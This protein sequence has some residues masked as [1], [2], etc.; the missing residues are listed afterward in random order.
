MFTRA[1]EALDSSEIVLSVGQRWIAISANLL[2]SWLGVNFQQVAIR[3]HLL[4][5]I[6]TITVP[7]SSDDACR[8]G[9]N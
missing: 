3:Q 1:L 2:L 8:V 6:H 5:I 4:L 7:Q 9:M